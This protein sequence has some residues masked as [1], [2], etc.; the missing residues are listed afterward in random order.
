[1]RSAAAQRRLIDD[2]LDVARLTTGKLRLEV[3]RVELSEAARAAVEN[4]RPVA[5]AKGVDLSAS[6]DA[7][8]LGTRADPVRLQQI[9]TNLLTNAIKFTPPGGRVEL[10]LRRAT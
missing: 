2:L 10:T 7:P 9:L 1:R 5:A 6:L 3:Q 4:V 8:A